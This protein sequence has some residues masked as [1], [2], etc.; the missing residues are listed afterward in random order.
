MELKDLLKKAYDLGGSDIFILPGARVT[1]KV[2]GDMVALSE[3]IE[4]P[5]DTEALI[6]EAGEIYHIDGQ[7]RL[8][9]LHNW[10]NDYGQPIERVFRFPTMNFSSYDCRKNVN[11]V[12]ITLGAYEAENTRLVYL[13]DYETRLDL[14]NLRVVGVSR[15]GSPDNQTQGVVSENRPSGT[16]PQSEQTPAVFRRRPMCRRVLHFTMKLENSNLN[17]DLELISAQVFFNQQG[18]LR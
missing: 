4:K 9:G 17:E 3:E 2:K 14:T 12:L 1:C 11:S 8:T 7:G 13:T 16:R 15:D 5:A 6:R 10:Y 18:R